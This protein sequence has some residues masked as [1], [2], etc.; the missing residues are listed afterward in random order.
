MQESEH[1]TVPWN[2]DLFVD[3]DVQDKNIFLIK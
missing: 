1:I 3:Q 2:Y